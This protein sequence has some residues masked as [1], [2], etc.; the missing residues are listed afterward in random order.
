MDFA[1][2][3]PIQAKGDLGA[4]MH[5]VGTIVFPDGTCHYTYLFQLIRT[6]V[7]F[8]H[9]THRFGVDILFCQFL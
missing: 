2:K 8:I 3:S 6:F 5:E 4:G 1:K 7:H 9:L